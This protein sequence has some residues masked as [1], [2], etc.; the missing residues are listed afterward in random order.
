MSTNQPAVVV[1]SRSNRRNPLS[2]LRSPLVRSY[3]SF[4]RVFPNKQSDRFECKQIS[5]WKQEMRDHPSLS[6]NDIREVQPLVDIPGSVRSNSNTGVQDFWLWA[7][8]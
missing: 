8:V 1:V 6:S 7:P 2:L 5:F 3:K 4:E